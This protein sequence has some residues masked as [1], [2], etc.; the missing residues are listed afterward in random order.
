MN[1]FHSNISPPLPPS[2]SESVVSQIRHAT[3]LE[4]DRHHMEYLATKRNELQEAIQI[5]VGGGGGNTHRKEIN[6][7][8]QEKQ[9]NEEL[10]N[11][12]NQF[13]VMCPWNTTPPIN[14]TAASVSASGNNDN[15][16][17]QR[18]TA[19]F[20]ASFFLMD[21]K[22]TGNIL[23]KRLKKTEKELVDVC[24]AVQRQMDSM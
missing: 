9:Y 20:S 13:F 2:S 21:S 1:N 8:H 5:V 23:Q 6:T 3:N 11:D 14:T 12:Q 22:S 16:K 18:D 19:L 17:T 4:S 7:I 24:E 15:R 10:Y